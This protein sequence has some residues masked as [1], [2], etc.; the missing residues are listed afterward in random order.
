MATAPAIERAPLLR[1]W[2]RCVPDSLAVQGPLKDQQK[3]ASVNDPRCES[4]LPLTL[5]LSDFEPK[6]FV[7][8]RASAARP[9]RTILFSDIAALATH[10]RQ[11]IAPAQQHPNERAIQLRSECAIDRTCHAPMNVKRSREPHLF[12]VRVRHE[13]VC[14][15]GEM[16][17][18]IRLY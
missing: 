6:V 2:R 11:P 7:R 16:L 14:H 18:H 12:Q 1:W 10:G 4:T 3:M 9:I 13:D 17:L 8:W 5:S 15:A